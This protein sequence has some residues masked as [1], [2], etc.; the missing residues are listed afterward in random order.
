M[1]LLIKTEGG[2]QHYAEYC[3]FDHDT[4]LKRTLIRYRQVTATPGLPD[5]VGPILPMLADN[6]TSLPVVNTGGSP[7]MVTQLVHNGQYHTKIITRRI[8]TE[9]I[10]EANWPTVEETVTDYAK[11]VMVETP[12]QRKIGEYDAIYWWVFDRRNPEKVSIEHLIE[13]G[14]RR[15]MGAS[16]QPYVFVATNQWLAT[17]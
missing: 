17:L 14:L 11:P 8:P 7:M 6:N 1:K 13:E 15:R 12:V 10:A 9:G 3:G 2:T 4:L 5:N 16:V